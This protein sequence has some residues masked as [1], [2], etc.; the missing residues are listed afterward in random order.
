VRNAEDANEPR[1]PGQSPSRR[2]PG[3]G[4]VRADFGILP[5][6][7]GKASAQLGKPLIE[8]I[9]SASI[10]NKEDSSVGVFVK[11]HRVWQQ[12][13]PLQVDF[14]HVQCVARTVL[15]HKAISKSVSPGWSVLR[16]NACGLDAVGLF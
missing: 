1:R 11:V 4:A 9:A 7:A 15:L 3:S 14:V 5:A 2:M 10:D 16:C 13:S 12:H 8:E 6:A